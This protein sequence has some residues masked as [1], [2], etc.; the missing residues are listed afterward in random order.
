MK[1]KYNKGDI[2]SGILSKDPNKICEGNKMFNLEGK[3]VIGIV[4][5]SDFYKELYVTTDGI[6]YASIPRKWITRIKRIGSWTDKK[7]NQFKKMQLI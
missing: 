6:T 7:Y 5:Y 1:I 4:D 2:V 3:K